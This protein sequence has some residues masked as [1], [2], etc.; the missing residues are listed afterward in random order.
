MNP[1]LKNAPIPLLFAALAASGR[2]G[3]GTGD[4]V[5]YRR[6]KAYQAKRND[7]CPCGSAKKYKRCCIDKI[8]L[9]PIE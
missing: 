1:A 9:Q 5:T 7:P 4:P 2:S 8:T 6:V 3:R